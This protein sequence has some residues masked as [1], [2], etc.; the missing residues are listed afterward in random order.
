M[1]S[2]ESSFTSFRRRR[3]S[4]QLG[5]GN[6]AM[7]GGVRSDTF[8]MALSY[9]FICYFEGSC[10][11]HGDVLYTVGMIPGLFKHERP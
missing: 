6:K 1:V 5:W 11:D 10:L 2:L 8:Y 7:A 3:G 4:T 9:L